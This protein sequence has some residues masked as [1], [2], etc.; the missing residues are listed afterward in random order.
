MNES[1]KPV[2]LIRDRKSEMG[3]SIAEMVVVMAIIGVVSIIAMMSYSTQK[4]YEAESQTFLIIDVLQ[5]ARQRALSQRTTMRVEV[6]ATKKMLRLIDERTSGD[7]SDDVLVKSIP[8]MEQGVYIGT[9]PANVSN[10]PTELSPVPVTPFENSTHPLSSGDSAIT[11]RFQRN[12]VVMSA[13]TNA[14][15]ANATP[16]GSTIYIWSKYADDNSA[17]PTQAQVMRAITVSA[18][19]GA[20]RMW[21]CL[22][23]NESCSNWTK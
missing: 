8:F 21:K 22:F 10:T 13:G 17:T 12:G 18:S 11:L 16:T 6:N 2:K 9:K 19:S 1:M 3:F 4:M 14:A 15:G 23:S 5:E 20:T 7:A